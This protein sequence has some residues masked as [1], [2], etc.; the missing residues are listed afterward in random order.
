[1][2]QWKSLFAYQWYLNGLLKAF[3]E[4]KDTVNINSWIFSLYTWTVNLIISWLK[5]QL[6]LS[7]FFGLEV[8]RRNFLNGARTK[9]YAIVRSSYFSVVVAGLSRRPKQPT[10]SVVLVLPDA[11][12]VVSLVRFNSCK[13][14]SRYLRWFRDSESVEFSNI[15]RTEKAADNIFRAT[16]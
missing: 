10:G 2:K 9:L 12:V 13:E 6:W 3:S 4:Q 8:G 11:S 16:S 15:G 5:L 1:M 14:V 7:S